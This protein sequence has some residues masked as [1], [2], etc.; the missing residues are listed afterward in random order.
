MKTKKSFEKIPYWQCV[1]LIKKSANYSRMK[2]EN[3]RWWLSL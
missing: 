1:R 3:E 2:Q